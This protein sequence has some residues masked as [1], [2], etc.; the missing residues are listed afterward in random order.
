MKQITAIV[1]IFTLTLSYSGLLYAMPKPIDKL[2]GGVMDV[3]TSPKELKDHTLMEVKGSK[4][5]PLAFIGGM[6]KGTAYMGKKAVGGALDIATF[7]ID[8]EK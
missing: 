7:P 4:M 5:L 3:V 2:K 1:V 6:L 8:L